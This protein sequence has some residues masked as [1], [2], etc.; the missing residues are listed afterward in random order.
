MPRRPRMFIGSSTEGLPVARALQAELEHD[1]DASVWSQG[2][3][4]LSASPLETLVETAA[5]VDFAVFVLSSRRPPRETWFS[6]RGP[7]RQRDLRGRAFHRGTRTPEHVSRLMPRRPGRTAHRSRGHHT[8][9]IQPPRRRSSGN[10][11]RSHCD[12]QQYGSRAAST[13][14]CGRTQGG[15]RVARASS[16]RCSGPDSKRQIRRGRGRKRAMGSGHHAVAGAAVPPTAWGART[17]I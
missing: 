14:S 10:W 1:V 13:E 4:G 9:S 2:V 3:F 15:V 6:G 8:G 17:E 5:S 11:A 7:P 12:P 16:D